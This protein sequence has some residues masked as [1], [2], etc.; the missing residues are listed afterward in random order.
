M[1]KTVLFLENLETLISRIINFSFLSPCILRFGLLK[2]VGRLLPK[3]IQI[4]PFPLFI[5]AFRMTSLRWFSLQN[6]NKGNTDKNS[7]IL[8]SHEINNP[9]T[10][11]LSVS[12]LSIQCSGFLSSNF[13]SILKGRI[14]ADRETLKNTVSVLRHNRA[15]PAFAGWTVFSS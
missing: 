9:N 12:F 5:R 8:L 15:R 4:F 11:S 6:N 10:P 3:V 2:H 14:Y 13:Y 1:H 7:P